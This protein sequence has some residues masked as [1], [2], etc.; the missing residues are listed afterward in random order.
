MKVK[1]Y[2]L[3]EQKGKKSDYGKRY[4]HINRHHTMNRQHTIT[5]FFLFCLKWQQP[6]LVT[7]TY[8]LQ[9]F[10]M[11]LSLLY[12]LFQVFLINFKLICMQDCCS[13][14]DLCAGLE[15][16][17]IKSFSK[18][19]FLYLYTE[20]FIPRSSIK[21]VFLEILQNSQENACARVSFLI[22]LQASGFRPATLL[23]KRFWHR[24]FLWIL[25]NF[26]EHL[27]SKNTSGGCI[28]IY[29]CMQHHKS[30]LCHLYSPH[31]YLCI[32]ACVVQIIEVSSSLYEKII[33]FI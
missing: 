4:N 3:W 6:K 28:Y 9:I 18:K 27:F 26:L 33:F 15:L 10:L 19:Y 25:R 2:S 30:F 21:K 24:C 29:I 7:T 32:F 16:S 5:I 14:T 1:S 11:L 20:A 22:K 17:Q 13:N 12:S 8:T 31:L 23:K